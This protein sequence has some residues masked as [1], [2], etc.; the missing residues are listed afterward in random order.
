VA[1]HLQPWGPH[2]LPLLTRLVGDPA[3]MEHLGG[4]ERPEKI[5]ERHARYLRRDPNTQMF[6]VVDEESGKGVGSVGY[7]PRA[8]R[9]NEVFETG[10]SVIPEFQ[11]R[12]IATAATA[13]LI[14]TVRSLKLRRYLHA[15]PSVDNA[16]SNAIC[17]KLGFTLLGATDFEYPAGHTM[18][19]NDWCLDLSAANR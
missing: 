6:K 15:F 9:G 16:A 5:S 14:D 4:P 19:C 1:V 2:D 8:W 10:W 7:W 3:M 12:G 17:R 13:K 11:G 18:R